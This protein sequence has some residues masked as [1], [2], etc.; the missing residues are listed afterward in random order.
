MPTIL[1][2]L[3]ETIPLHP[4]VLISKQVT[5]RNSARWQREFTIP[6]SQITSPAG[7]RRSSMIAP[8]T[9]RSRIRFSNRKRR[10]LP[11]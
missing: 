5:I 3:M 2:H 6:P 8:S 4:T 11:S 1:D 7:N 9:A 10:R